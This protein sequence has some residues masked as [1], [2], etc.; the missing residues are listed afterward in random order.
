[1]PTPAWFVSLLKTFF[2]YR[3]SIAR[4]SRLPV[5]GLMIDQVVF[6]NDDMVYLPKDRVVIREAIEQPGS[7]VLPSSIVEH[8]IEKAD[9]HWIMNKCICR[10]GDDCQDYPHDLGCIFLGEAA[11]RIDLRL[12]HPATKEEAL[13]HARKARE[14][15]LVHLIGRDRLDTLWMGVGP[16]EKLMTICNCCPCCCLFRILPDLTP[17]ISQRIKRLPGVEVWVGA[18]CNGCGKCVRTGCFVDAITMVD[19]KARISDACR[20]CGRC[21][22]VCPTQAI[23]LRITDE[24]YLANTIRRISRVVDV[25][26]PA[27]RIEA[28]AQ[29]VP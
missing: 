23:H 26:A 18:E 12:G 27:G 25:N 10:E 5:I 14:A 29:D 4:L 16:S 17:T 13:E 11:T 15:G 21:V 7:V 9:Y 28:P 24:S 22:E 3:K 20:G 6:R 19:G 8:F 1:M 2:P